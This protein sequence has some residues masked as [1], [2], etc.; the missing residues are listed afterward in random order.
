MYRPYFLYRLESEKWG[1]GVQDLKKKPKNTAN[2]GGVGFPAHLKEG[3]S[4]L[5]RCKVPVRGTEPLVYISN[6]KP[7]SFISHILNRFSSYKPLLFT[8]SDS[9]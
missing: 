8:A 7:L 3:Q 5:D 1:V 4:Y 2:P 9:F 6:A